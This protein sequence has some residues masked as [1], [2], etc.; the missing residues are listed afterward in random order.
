MRKIQRNKYKDCEKTQEKLQY[1]EE[2]QI[3]RRKLRKRI[4]EQRKSHQR[5]KVNQGILRLIPYYDIRI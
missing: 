3:L 2:L 1:E 4:E 5:F